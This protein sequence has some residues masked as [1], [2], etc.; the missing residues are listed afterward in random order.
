MDSDLHGPAFFVLASPGLVPLA[1]IILALVDGLVVLLL[2]VRFALMI[3]SVA[4][5]LV[6]SFALLRND[7]CSDLI[8]A[9]VGKVPLEEFLVT[10]DDLFEVLDDCVVATLRLVLVVKESAVEVT[11]D[12][13]FFHDS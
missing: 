7:A 1:V 8:E 2:L 6:L 13:D 10:F 4:G 5:L 11:N 3:P 9:I 12:A